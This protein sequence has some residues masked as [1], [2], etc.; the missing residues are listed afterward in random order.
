M[1]K[2]DIRK[3]QQFAIETLAKMDA[4]PADPDPLANAVR[5]YVRAVLFHTIEGTAASLR[6]D[7]IEAAYHAS[8]VVAN[9]DAGWLLSLDV[10]TVH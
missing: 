10:S 6:G 8:R 1:T 9:V 7:E 5:P 2:R 3:V 4:E